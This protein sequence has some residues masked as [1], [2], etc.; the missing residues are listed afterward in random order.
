MA[1]NDRNRR[2][3]RVVWPVIRQGRHHRAG[4]G[5][6]G[7]ALAR[8]ADGRALTRGTLTG[9]VRAR[10]G[11]TTGGRAF[12]AGA[13]AGRR[14]TG[15]TAGGHMVNG[16]AVDGHAVDGRGGRRTGR[17]EWWSASAAPPVSIELTRIVVAL[18][19]ATLGRRLRMS[20]MS[21]L[22]PEL[23]RGSPEGH[24][25]RGMGDRRRSARAGDGRRGAGAGEG[26]RIARRPVLL[27]AVVCLLG[28][29]GAMAAV[30][31]AYDHVMSLAP[32]VGGLLVV[33]AVWRSGAGRSG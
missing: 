31:V 17:R 30:Q 12:N 20:P 14:V 21:L 10:G 33:I 4:S 29:L 6:G 2:A 11:G 1:R 23:G 25:R 7:R 22:F 5:A 3:S 27:G 19:P 18:T 28:M 9:R 15:R 16:H 24:G 26:S 13:V 32:F 8:G